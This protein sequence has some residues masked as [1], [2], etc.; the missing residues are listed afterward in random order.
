MSVEI[1]EIQP[2]DVKSPRLRLITRH[3]SGISKCL[4]AK[5]EQEEVGIMIV[6]LYDP[7]SALFIYYIYVV[8]NFRNQGIGSKLLWFAESMASKRG[9]P[10]VVLQPNEI[11]QGFSIQDL[12]SW[13]TKRGYSDRKS[14]PKRMA[15]I[16]AP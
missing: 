11:E 2:T 12:R 10:S 16:L 6:D 3:R 7:P 8:P 4:L 13:Y 1:I 14:D 5:V 9:N 15:K